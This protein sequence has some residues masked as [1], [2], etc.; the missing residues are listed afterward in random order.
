[1]GKARATGF[2]EQERVIPVQLC[3]DVD[4]KNIKYKNVTRRITYL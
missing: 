3:K 1:M 2:R 4:Q